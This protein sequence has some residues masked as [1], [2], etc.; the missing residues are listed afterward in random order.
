MRNS[1]CLTCC[2]GRCFRAAKWLTCARTGVQVWTGPHAG[3][4]LTGWQTGTGTGWT[5]WQTVTGLQAPGKKTSAAPVTPRADTAMPI[6]RAISRFFRLIAIFLSNCDR[7]GTL[8][9]FLARCGTVP[10]PRGVSKRRPSRP[11]RSA[12][13]SGRPRTATAAAAPRNGRPAE[14]RGRRNQSMPG[15]ASSF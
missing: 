14:R 13:E 7:W 3:T 8:S 11:N 9:R 15:R 4:A 1:E 10:L 12:G 2:N 5:C 6:A